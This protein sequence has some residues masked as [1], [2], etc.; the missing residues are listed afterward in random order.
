MFA[1][2]TTKDRLQVIHLSIYKG[3][4]VTEDF[5]CDRV[6]DRV[7]SQNTPAMQTKESRFCCF[8]SINMPGKKFQGS[9][10]K[11]Q[12]GVSPGSLDTALV[13]HPFSSQQKQLTNFPRVLTATRQL[14]PRPCCRFSFATALYHKSVLT[15]T[16]DGRTHSWTSLLTKSLCLPPFL[17]SRKAVIAQPQ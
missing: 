1:G 17:Y 11:L 8:E 15:L 5:A 6:L 7:V 13:T 2:I 9:L 14:Q 12:L 16:A 4:W 3:F 10:T